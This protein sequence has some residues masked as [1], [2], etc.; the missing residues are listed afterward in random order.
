ME[1]LWQTIASLSLN[2]RKWLAKRLEEDIEESRLTEEENI[3]I[4][5]G[6][7][8]IERGK[9]IRIQNINNIWESIS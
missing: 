8:E 6:F 9:T 2:N 3:A 4:K 1:S 5:K 7:K